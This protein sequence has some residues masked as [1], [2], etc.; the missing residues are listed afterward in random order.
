MSELLIHSES[1]GSETVMTVIGEVHATT[2]D[3]LRRA[4]AATPS[5]VEVLDCRFV[6]FMSAAGLTALVEWHRGSPLRIVTSK[7]VDRVLRVC[8]L[9]EEFAAASPAGAPQLTSAPFGLAV[10]DMDLRFV[11]VNR[12]LAQIN[13]VVR[14]KHLG[15]RPD[16]LFNASSDPISPLLTSVVETRRERSVVIGGNTAGQIGGLW[17]CRYRP[18][19]HRG[20]PVVVATVEPVAR[21]EAESGAAHLDFTRLSIK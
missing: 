14:D 8:G 13:G 7:R 10:H 1:R 21:H 5:P 6:T 20:E 12:T 3:H 9:M 4:F 19:H 18:A 11:Y 17:S 15:R 2:A 16:E